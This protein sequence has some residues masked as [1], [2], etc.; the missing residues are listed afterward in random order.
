MKHLPLLLSHRTTTTNL[1]LILLLFLNNQPTGSIRHQIINNNNKSVKKQIHGL[2]D[3]R[4]TPSLSVSIHTRGGGDEEDSDDDEEDDEG[5]EVTALLGESSSTSPVIKIFNLLGKAT[6]ITVKA[7]GRSISAAF[8]EIQ[9]VMNN[10]DNKEDSSSIVTKLTKILGSMWNA[11]MN[12]QED[13]NNID[14]LSSSDEIR[15]FGQFLSAQYGVTDDRLEGCSKMLGGAMGD[16]LT[17][18]RSQARLFVA[19]IP[20]SR[21]TGGKTKTTTADHH[22][23][24]SLLSLEVSQAGERKSRKNAASEGSF[25]FWGAKAGSPDAILAT[26][27]LKAKQPKK[28]KRPTLLVAYPARVINSNTG[29]PQIVPR[30][31]AQHHCS[32]PPSPELM[33]QWLNALRKR[34]AKKEFASMLHDLNEVKLLQERVSGYR[35]SVKSDKDREEREKEEEQEQL[36]LEEEEQTRLAEIETRRIELKESLPEEPLK[37]TEG[38]VTIALRF[39]DGRASQRRFQSDTELGTIFNWVDA[40]Y[41]M[42]R[43]KIT[44]TTMNGQKTFQWNEEDRTK[45][46]QEA[47]LGRMTGLRVME[48]K[49][50]EIISNEEKE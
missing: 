23:I 45:T 33:A 13:E 22:A 3:F 40:M 49:P 47:G 16:A 31:L 37:T 48:T 30:L 11:A 18:A 42:E 28:G 43:E 2:V 7:V 10:S 44:L 46:L 21:P 6:I 14:S 24:R 39:A 29:V 1:F 41:T 32:P 27:R 17:Q 20:A 50:E 38:V 4:K 5:E 25:L 12:P 26:K 34:H 8:V 15:D 9:E 35:D 36:R 19:F